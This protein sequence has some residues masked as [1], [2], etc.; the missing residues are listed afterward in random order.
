MF[1]EKVWLA[2]DFS[3]NTTQATYLNPEQGRVRE[4]Q[5]NSFDNQFKLCEASTTVVVDNIATV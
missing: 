3:F 2:P 5:L 4:I 1:Q